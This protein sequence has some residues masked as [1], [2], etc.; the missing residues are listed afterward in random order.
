MKIPEFEIITKPDSYVRS[1]SINNAIIGIIFFTIDGNDFPT[2][3]WD[4]FVIIILGWW[5]E[6]ALSLLDKTNKSCN[7]RFMDGPYLVR[8]TSDEEHSWLVQ[9]I[10]TPAN[11]GEVVEY[12]TR[13]AP[14]IL[15]TA[16]EGAAAAAIHKCNEQNWKSPD[17]SF[18]ISVRNR[19][20]D[21]L[22]R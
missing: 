9:G 21:K 18:L 6:A 3:N 19:I 17:I 16:I 20:Q 22:T 1:E 14:K 15:L 7:F 5:V 8:V 4:D 11:I 12:E 10:K 2:S 13:I